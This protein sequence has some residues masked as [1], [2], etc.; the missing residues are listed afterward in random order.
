LKENGSPSRLPFLFIPPSNG[1]RIMHPGGKK[2]PFVSF[3]PTWTFSIPIFDGCNFHGT[4]SHEIPKVY[5]KIAAKSV[6]ECH[7]R[8]AGELASVCIIL[9]RFLLFRAGYFL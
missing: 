2:T 9:G 1:R 7:Q 8:R 3:I 6:Q 5:G 4:P